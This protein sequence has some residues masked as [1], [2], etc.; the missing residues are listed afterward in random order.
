MSDT[1][2]ALEDVTEAAWRRAV[3][4]GPLTTLWPVWRALPVSLQGRRLTV[5]LGP[6]LRPT[7]K[8][9]T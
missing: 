2:T 9:I 7:G 1:T 3:M 6:W 4:P 5:M 8:W